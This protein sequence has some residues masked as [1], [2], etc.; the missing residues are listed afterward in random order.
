MH[1]LFTLLFIPIVR[2]CGRQRL[3][4]PHLRPYR[5]RLRKAELHPRRSVCITIY[6]LRPTIVRI[7]YPCPGEKQLAAPAAFPFTVRCFGSGCASFPW[8]VINIC[9]EIIT[10]AANPVSLSDGPQRTLRASA[11]NPALPTYHVTTLPALYSAP[12]RR[13]A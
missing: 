4:Y 8:I 2:A 13:V 1:A 5:P 3:D 6:T 7:H 10:R 12:T 9:E 11:A